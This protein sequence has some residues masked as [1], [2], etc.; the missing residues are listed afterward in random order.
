[1]QCSSLASAPP[2][3]LA[4]ANARGE[5]GLSQKTPL[6]TLQRYPLLRGLEEGAEPSDE[7]RAA[8]LPRDE[9]TLR[10]LWLGPRV[11]RIV[12]LFHHGELARAAMSDDGQRY[13]WY[14]ASG[15][16]R[17]HEAWNRA[18]RL[19][20][21]FEARRG[22]SFLV[23]FD[24]ATGEHVIFEG[25]GGSRFQTPPVAPEAIAAEPSSVEALVRAAHARFGDVEAL[26]VIADRLCELADPRGELMALQLARGDD[27]P[28]AHVLV[29]RHGYQWMPHGVSLADARFERG[30]LVQARVIEPVDATHP[31][32]QTIRSMH[33]ES[34]FT[35]DVASP[36]DAN[37]PR[38][39]EL[40]G[41]RV[42]DLLPCLVRV[43]K[44]LEVLHCG[45]VESQRAELL[46]MSL[47][48]FSSLHTLGFNAVIEPRGVLESV[49]SRRPARLSTLW[50]PGHHF[51]PREVQRALA[52]VADLTVNL[53]FGWLEF[54]EHVAWVSVT[55]RELGLHERGRKVPG[56]DLLGSARALL[57]AAGIH[58]PQITSH[59]R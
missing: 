1:M 51:S 48:D 22:S 37:L 15:V 41:L 42:M 23:A 52:N 25:S 26:R 29:R 9:A 8:H 59:P 18:R 19:N 49:L 33:F 47:S 54:D 53:F 32:W 24:P 13:A 36:F 5:D 44:E 6:D 43:P 40:S 46:M 56:P 3:A 35:F 39:R 7:E 50:L 2:L 10:A 30:C 4:C 38:L 34:S 21:V 20:T 55:G 58:D 17:E 45:H 12:E 11:E 16:L 57:R 14:D 27:A 31:A 28:G